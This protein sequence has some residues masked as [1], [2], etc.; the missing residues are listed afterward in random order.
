MTSKEKQLE[1]LEDM[2][3]DML[4]DAHREMEEAKKEYRLSDD[5][6]YFMQEFEEEFVAVIDAVNSL[7]VLHSRFNHDFDIKDFA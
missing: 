7:K 1:F 2:R 5:Y 4:R 3:Q 6:D